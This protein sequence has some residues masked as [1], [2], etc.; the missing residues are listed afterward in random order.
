MILFG[1]VKYF[2]YVCIGLQLSKEKKTVANTPFCYI[3]VC[4][5]Y[6]KLS[7]M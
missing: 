7:K 1:C 6:T 2:T 4:S 5:K 3:D